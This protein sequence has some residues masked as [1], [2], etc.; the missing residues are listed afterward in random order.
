MKTPQDHMSKYPTRHRKKKVHK[1][2]SKPVVASATMEGVPPVIGTDTDHVPYHP[3][4]PDD[5]TE[6]TK[7]PPILLMAK[8][9][10]PKKM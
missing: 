5:H 2:D 10:I 8:K 3:P 7:P 4:P 1:T 9:T 6:D